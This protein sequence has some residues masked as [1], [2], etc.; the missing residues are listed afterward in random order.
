LKDQVY[1]SDPALDRLMAICLALGTE[2]H[3]LRHELATLRSVLHEQ[4]L[5]DAQRL[6]Q[7][8]TTQSSPEQEAALARHIAAMLGPLLADAPDEAK[9]G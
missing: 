1:F 2:L 7:P 8:A 5:I 3:V 6:A 4:G 9:D